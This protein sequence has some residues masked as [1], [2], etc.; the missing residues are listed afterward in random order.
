MA[1]KRFDGSAFPKYGTDD[2][3]DEEVVDLEEGAEKK[4]GSK[5]EDS[6]EMEAGDRSRFYKHD[7]YKDDME[8]YALDA[9]GVIM[10]TAQFTERKKHIDIHAQDPNLRRLV[11]REKAF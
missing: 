9:M 4:E 10:D 8:Q 2:F 7:L 5:E 1:K 3:L 6:D 11:L